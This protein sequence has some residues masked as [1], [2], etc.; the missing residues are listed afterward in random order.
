[1]RPRV[2]K[3]K[4][5]IACTLYLSPAELAEARRR[6]SSLGQPLSIWLRSQLTSLM[7]VS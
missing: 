2:Q 4:R 5:R 3:A 7:V 1:M 6:A